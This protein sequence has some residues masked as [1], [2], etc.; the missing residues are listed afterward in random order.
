MENKRGS[1]SGISDLG[2]RRCNE[3]LLAVVKVS[4]ALLK[5]L[6]AVVLA[7]G[8]PCLQGCPIGTYWPL[9]LTNSTGQE[10]WLGGRNSVPDVGRTR[11]RH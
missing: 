4:A 11:K 8:N 5:P 10:P 9:R 7:L 6:Q 1:R 2:D 3:V